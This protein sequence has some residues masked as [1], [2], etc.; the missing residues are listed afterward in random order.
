MTLGECA[1]RLALCILFVRPTGCS[2]GHLDVIERVT[3]PEA[4]KDDGASAL[5][6][7]GWALQFDGAKNCAQVSN[8]LSEDFTLEAWVRLSATG[9]G[10]YWWEGLPLFWSDIDRQNYDFSVVLLNG[11]LRFVTGAPGGDVIVSSNSSIATSEWIHIAV[12]REE[13]SGLV[14]IF[15]GGVADGSTEGTTGPLSAQSDLWVFCSGAGQYT[16]GTIDELRAW[17]IVRSEADL[18]ATMRRRL[19][20]TEPGLVGYW[21]FEEGAG[22]TAADRSPTKHPLVLLGSSAGAPPSWVPSDAPVDAP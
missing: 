9:A 5:P 13:S 2:P 17:N 7:A 4:G 14:T 22:T 11:L 12:T 1:L 15:V 10:T 3:D 20:G 21:R 16:P 18:Q 6:L 19:V 8:P